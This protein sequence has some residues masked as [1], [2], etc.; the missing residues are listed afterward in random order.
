MSDLIKSKFQLDYQDFE[1]LSTEQIKNLD[2]INARIH[3]VEHIEK[4]KEEIAGLEISLAAETKMVA[5]DVLKV[6]IF[7]R[8]GGYSDFIGQEFVSQ[9]VIDSNPTFGNL[10]TAV[11]MSSDDFKDENKIHTMFEYALE[12]FIF[13]FFEGCGAWQNDNIFGKQVAIDYDYRSYVHGSD[14]YPSEYS[15]YF[16]VT[17]SK[18]GKSYC[19]EFTFFDLKRAID[20]QYAKSFHSDIFPTMG[21]SSLKPFESIRVSE[22][23]KIFCA[24]SRL[25]KSKHDGISEQQKKKI[26][27]KSFDPLEIAAFVRHV[28]FEDKGEI[29]E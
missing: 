9:E 7:P 6:N 3:Q 5:D 4:L 16:N 24:I 15:Y 26:Y 1:T 8:F 10:A 17:N 12:N 11:E 2:F 20:V 22:Y 23:G 18:N 19:V 29:N 13:V 25:G 21:V 27:I 14:A 28:V